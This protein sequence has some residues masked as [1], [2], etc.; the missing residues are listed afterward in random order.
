MERYQ[1]H[2]HLL[3]ITPGD[4]WQQLRGAYKSQMRRWHPDR[5]AQSDV[6]RRHAEEQT[7]Q[8]N[9]AYQ[10]LSEYYEQHGKLPLDVATPA[11]S[12]THPQSTH[13][14]EASTPDMQPAPN[15]STPASNESFAK[16][17]YRAIIVGL[18]ALLL[19]GA[20]LW[21][22]D[23]TDP[24]RESAGT[25]S[26]VSASQHAASAS[27][28]VPPDMPVRRFGVGST[29]GEVYSIQGIP[30]K[31][32]G[33]VWYFGEARVLFEK[34]RVASWVDSNPPQLK[35][36]DE[37]KLTSEP[38]ITL[39]TRGSSKTEVRAAQGTP[40]RESEDVWD[41]GLSRVYFDRSGLV[42]G[43]QESQLDPLHI[44]R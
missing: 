4:S 43:W 12:V 10:E 16:N 22:T 28:K 27:P 14:S 34:G 9:Q 19:I 5:F 26:P 31:V 32:N 20:L 37:I 40:L 39:F 23:P 29:L 2:Y 25:A 17:A 30:T 18:I 33:D 41:Y 6:S 1:D 24:A 44:K 7:K 36:R 21:D 15:W 42:S 3:G 13:G 11:A 35:V 38:A 8:I